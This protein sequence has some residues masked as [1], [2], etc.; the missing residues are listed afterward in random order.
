MVDVDNGGMPPRTLWEVYDEIENLPETAKTG[1][2]N[3]VSMMDDD[4]WDKSR[5]EQ[6]LGL[7]VNMDGMNITQK[8]IAR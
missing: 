2:T 5:R 4:F 1:M 3:L 8:D 7:L 6:V